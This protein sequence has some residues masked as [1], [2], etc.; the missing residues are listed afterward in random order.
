MITHTIEMMLTF[1]WI[2]LRIKPIISG[3]FFPLIFLLFFNYN[4]VVG[5]SSTNDTLKYISYT[6][7]IVYLLVC[8]RGNSKIDA[9]RMKE[10]SLIHI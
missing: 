8:L 9:Q 2:P 5:V 4:V 7:M 1:D 6:T 3:L 10:L